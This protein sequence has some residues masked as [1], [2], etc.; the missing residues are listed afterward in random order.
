MKEKVQKACQNCE[1]KYTIEWDLEQQDMN[2]ATCPF[3]GFE[4]GEEDDEIWTNK[5]EDDSWN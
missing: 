3:C 5:D 4:V 1:T 2:P